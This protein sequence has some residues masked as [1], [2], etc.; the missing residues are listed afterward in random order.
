MYY[1]LTGHKP[2]KGN[3]DNDVINAITKGYINYEIHCGDISPIG[4]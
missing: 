4:K 2:F 3:S 1:M